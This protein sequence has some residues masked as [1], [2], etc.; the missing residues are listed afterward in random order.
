M[1]TEI[2]AIVRPKGEVVQRNFSLT[3]LNGSLKGEKLYFRDVFGATISCDNFKQMVK[4]KLRCMGLSAEISVELFWG[5][6]RIECELDFFEMWRVAAEDKDGFVTLHVDIIGGGDADMDT[7]DDVGVDMASNNGF[8]MGGGVGVDMAV[9]I[10]GIS[11]ENLDDGVLENILFRLPLG[12]PSS[13]AKR[14]CQLWKS[15]LSNRR[16]N[17]VGFLFAC[18]DSKANLVDGKI[19]LCFGE[20]YDHIDCNRMNYYYSHETLMEMEHC[21]FV[22]K[23]HPDFD[24]MVGSCN[25][26]VC[27]QKEDP[28]DRYVQE[29]FAVCNPSTGEFIFLK[30]NLRANLN[31]VWESRAVVVS[32]GFGYCHLTSEYK[33]VRLYS[34]GGDERRVSYAQVY[35]IGSNKWRDMETLI[36]GTLF[37]DS[38]PGV[39]ANGFLHWLGNEREARHLVV[40]DL[41]DEK[42]RELPLPPS[43]ADEDDYSNP[44]NELNLLGGNLCWLKR[45]SFRIDIWAYKKNVVNSGNT[46][47]GIEEHDQNSWN[48]VKDFSIEYCSGLLECSALYDQPFAITK[49][50]QVL[51]LGTSHIYCYDPE[52]RTISSLRKDM[53]MNQVIPHANSYVSLKDFGETWYGPGTQGAQQFP[54]N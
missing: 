41:E 10:R 7:G 33:V 37:Y 44:I 22:F 4:S 9:S 52:T 19:H 27:F 39:F 13:Q 48:W 6:D 8:D 11:I 16:H 47:Y 46:R 12:T 50:S 28:G 40:F 25:G 18:R 24:I 45:T 36:D 14:V 17:E 30:E 1:K 49:S 42:F 20:E 15:I 34:I 26:L 32:N 35:T 53:G 43:E 29:A 54:D 21:R 23:S 51:V 5:N 31:M 3:V 2:T 38:G